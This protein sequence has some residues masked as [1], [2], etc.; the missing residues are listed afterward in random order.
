MNSS[1]IYH[2]KSGDRDAANIL[3]DFSFPWLNYPAPDTEFR[4]WHDGETFSFEF[5]V[6]DHDLV[7]SESS[8]PYL[9][10]LESD[11]VELFFS[12]TTDLSE[13]YYGFEMDPRG[14]VYDYKGEFHRKFDPTWHLQSLQTRGKLTP[15]GYQLEGSLPISSLIELNL[16]RDRQMVTG[17]YRAEFSHK[18]NGTIQQDWIS[19]IAPDTETPDFHIPDSF[20]RFVFED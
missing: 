4:A 7:I 6:E 11:R 15:R 18:S 2:V 5:Q 10:V 19:W 14:L 9:R 17:V 13:T 1:K 8:D 3:T 20:G 12:P 16:L